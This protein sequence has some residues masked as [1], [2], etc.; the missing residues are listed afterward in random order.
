[1]ALSKLDKWKTL[2]INE[3]ICASKYEMPINPNLLTSLLCF[4]SP[5]TNTFSIPEGF[6]TATGAD[7]FVLLGLC[8][9]GALAH[10]L[11]AVGTGPN[12][13][14]NILNGVS[15]SYNEF[16]KQMKGSNASPIT[17]KEEC[18]LYLL[19]ICR[20]LAYTS[21][22]RVINYYLPITQCLANGIHVDMSSFLLGELYRTMFLLSIEPKQSHGGP[23]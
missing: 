12:E 21:S 20:F 9:M 19:W 10:P 1:M 2:G 14:V 15:L 11:M 23:G 6:M 4:W 17:Y 5:A 18:C 16:I 3:A 13:D 22:K 8:P 7:I